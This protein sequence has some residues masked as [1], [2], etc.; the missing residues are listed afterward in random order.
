[1]MIYNHTNVF[2]VQLVD[3]H[4]MFYVIKNRI[5]E[6]WEL[7]IWDKYVQ[8]YTTTAHKEKLTISLEIDIHNFYNLAAS[9][10]I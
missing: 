9:E 2:I 3:I 6:R 10:I 8:E 5:Y 7:Y 4:F 1:M